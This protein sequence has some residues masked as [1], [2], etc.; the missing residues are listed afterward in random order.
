MPGAT[1]WPIRA[2]G[3]RPP[4]EQELKGLLA[5]S[6]EEASVADLMDEAIEKT[7]L[8]GM[9]SVVVTDFVIADGAR[10]VTV[11]LPSAAKAEPAKEWSTACTLQ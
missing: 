1:R 7:V 8:G 5:E 6:A 2:R 3:P 9:V 11:K 10:L 4:S